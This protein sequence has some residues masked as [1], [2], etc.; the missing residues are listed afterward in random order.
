MRKISSS[1]GLKKK[2]S[3]LKEDENKPDMRR[4]LSQ[5]SIKKKPTFKEQKTPSSA[6]NPRSKKTIPEQI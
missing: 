1:L 6:Y 4:S 5:F 2:Y 3:S